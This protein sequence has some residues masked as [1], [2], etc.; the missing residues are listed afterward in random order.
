M[1]VE[2]YDLC[3]KYSCGCIIL[4][5]H[6]HSC[7]EHMHRARSVRK[8]YNYFRVLLSQ[9]G[10][11][12]IRLFQ[13][14]LVDYVVDPWSGPY[15]YASYVAQGGVRCKSGHALHLHF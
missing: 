4:W 8:S 12:V 6:V 13:S 9:V 11:K 5:H 14:A 7:H 1:I 2:V 15:R 3:G 10:E